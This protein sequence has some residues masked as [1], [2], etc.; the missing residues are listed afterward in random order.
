MAAEAVPHRGAIG[1]YGFRSGSGHVCRRREP[2]AWL[3]EE[4]RRA[5]ELAAESL[6]GDID[7]D[8]ILEFGNPMRRL[9]E[10]AT[11]ARALLLVV[12]VNGEAAERAPSIVARGVSRRAPCPVVIVPESAAVPALA[13]TGS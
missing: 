13:S 4:A 12:G 3:P 2:P 10:F 8:C 1:H 5:L 11:G 7:V 9:I 6:D